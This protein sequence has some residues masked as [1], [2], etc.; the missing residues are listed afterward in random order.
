MEATD[1]VCCIWILIYIVFIGTLARLIYLTY[2]I[3]TFKENQEIVL[4]EENGLKKIDDTEEQTP[5]VIQS[6]ISE[7]LNGCKFVVV[8][9]I[10]A[11]KPQVIK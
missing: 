6:F 3:S 9:Q 10:S 7:Q 11:K 4:D 5:D 1:V 8:H 2:W